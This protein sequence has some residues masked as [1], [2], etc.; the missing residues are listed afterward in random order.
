MIR[1]QKQFILL[2]AALFAAIL[3]IINIH[4]YVDSSRFITD[5]S[6]T[7]QVLNT[8]RL[9]HP[10]VNKPSEHKRYP[11]LHKQDRLHL[12]MVPGMKRLYVLSG[13]RVIYIMHARTTI[14][15]QTVTA[16][17]Q[18]G[19]QIAHVGDGHTLAGR[20][21]SALSH[22]CY[23]IAPAAIDQ[24]RVAKNWLKN[25]FAFPNTIQLSRP[26]AQWLQGLPKNTKITIR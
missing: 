17:D 11:A 18:H 10:N 5:A 23:I 15:H 6:R 1:K 12:V 2:M 21:W 4:A 14:T 26:D 16:L 7:S 20:D 8:N 9:R 3:L 24:D 25:T 22:Q 13:Q 19:Q